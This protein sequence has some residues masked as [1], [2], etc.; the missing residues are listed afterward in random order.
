MGWS[1]MTFDKKYP[2]K[3]LDNLYVFNIANA[4]KTEKEEFL[5]LNEVEMMDV[6]KNNEPE[7]RKSKSGFGNKKFYVPSFGNFI[8]STSEKQYTQFYDLNLAQN[9][10]EEL[11][12]DFEQIYLG[13]IYYYE[14]LRELLA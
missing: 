7:V 13:M 3:I 1:K 2:V 6:L 11:F 5:K 4:D 10:S 14:E 8:V 9:K 12:F